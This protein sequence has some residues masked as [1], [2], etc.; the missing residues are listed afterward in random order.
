L[1]KKQRIGLY[2]GTF[3]PIHNGHIIVAESV[4]S[5]LNLDLIYFIPAHIHAFKP[6]EGIL[7]AKNRLALLK[8]ALKKY[9]YFRISTIELDS[10]ETSYTIDTIKKFRKYEK[11]NDSDLFYII[12]ADNLIE[13]EYWKSP[14]EIMS[15]SN[16]V[17]LNRPNQSLQEK[18]EKYKDKIILTDTPLIE[19]SST[20]IRER[21]KKNHHWQ[22]L[23]PS[24]VFKYIQK[25]HLYK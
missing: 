13:L 16:L 25:H 17:V 7:P 4:I 15:L 6:A 21:I 19:I 20:I 8:L 11:L 10:N 22:S 3:D 1:T 18:L 23:V 5:N 14:D 12:G 2:G 24:E 9:P